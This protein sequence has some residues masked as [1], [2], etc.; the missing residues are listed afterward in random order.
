MGVSDVGC[1]ISCINHSFFLAIGQ[2]FSSDEYIK[3][4]LKELS[5]VGISYEVMRREPLRL[6]GLEVYRTMGDGAAG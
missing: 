4:F 2:N 1:E 3:A 6:C 5:S